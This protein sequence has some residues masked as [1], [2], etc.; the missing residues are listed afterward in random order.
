MSLSK[1]SL[2]C[3]NAIDIK[4]INAPTFNPNKAI[5]HAAKICY[6]SDISTIS[7]KDIDIK[8][9]LFE[10]GHHTTLQHTFFTFLI[11]GISIGN[12]TFGLH[13][14]H[15]FYNTDQRSG[16]YSSKMFSNPDISKIKDYINNFWEVDKNTLDAIISYIKN[17]IDAYNENTELATEIVKQF[18][19]KERPFASEKYIELNAKKI[20]Q[21]QLRMFMPVIFPTALDFTINLSALIAMYHSAFDPVMK[22]VFSK[23]ADL[24]LKYMQTFD[25]DFSYMFDD[26]YSISDILD[27]TLLKKDIDIK[28]RPNLVLKSIQGADD[29]VIPENKIKFPIDMLYFSPDM[30]ENTQG[31]V[32]SEIE[33]SV[34][35]MGQDQ[36]HRTIKRGIPSFTGNFYIPP[37]MKQLGL[38]NEVLNLMKQWVSLY[39]NIPNSLFYTLSPYGA[40]VR[41][42][43]FADFNALIHEQSKRLCWCT[44]EEIYHL[45]LELRREVAKNKGSNHPIVSIFEPPCYRYRCI[46]GNRYCGR[47][48]SKKNSI[49]EFFIE[50][51]V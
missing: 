29:F 3:D 2:L 8:S 40:M 21:E 33:V 28:Y 46:E 16:R 12:V 14:S 25:I 24:V 13:L 22:S 31:Y 10:T 34:A 27:I 9:L 19:P 36:R 26:S 4:L 35:T 38:E 15:P 1:Y 30:M 32:Q 6:I 37:M 41:Y 48:L 42:T 39:E 43:K 20:A 51:K 47:D 7:D 50:R 5:S 11:D 45:S 44:Q 17:G 18:I 23:M 49:D